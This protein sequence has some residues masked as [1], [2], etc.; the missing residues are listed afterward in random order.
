LL[1][2]TLY[3]NYNVYHFPRLNKYDYKYVLLHLVTSDEDTSDSL[4]TVA[5]QPWHLNIG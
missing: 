3:N 2:P 1:N 4:V 5:I